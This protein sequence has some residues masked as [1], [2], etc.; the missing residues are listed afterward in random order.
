M[1]QAGGGAAHR[2]GVGDGLRR[3]GESAQGR[4]TAWERGRREVEKG[5]CQAS[6]MILTNMQGGY[7][8]G[9]V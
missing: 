2:A 6:A 3:R 5:I 1:D 9:Y 7:T 4:A 8:G